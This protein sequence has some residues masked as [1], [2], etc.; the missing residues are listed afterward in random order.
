MIDHNA[1]TQ[2]PAVR[3]A[4][5]RRMIARREALL[6]QE[7]ARMSAEIS[8]HLL[9][10][11]PEPPGEPVG[12]CWPI[13][14]EPDIRAALC[15]W[16]AAGTRLALPV[17]TPAEPLRFRA[18]RP[19]TPLS[20][21]PCGI[22]APESGAWLIPKVLLIP[23]NAFNRD[24]FRLGYGGGLFD[25]TLATLTPRPLVI[26]LGFAFNQTEALQPEAHDQAMD[27]IF[28]ETGGYR[29]PLARSASQ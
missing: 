27:W 28:T 21:D 17:A 8:A 4:L 14:N 10:I 26:G 22:P 18:W 15:R 24:G 7:V 6:P 2:N 13:R 25:R 16:Q 29:F 5:R 19:G 23:V 20:P 3:K 1:E 12:F 9:A 11:F